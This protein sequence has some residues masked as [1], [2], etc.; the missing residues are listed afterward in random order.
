MNGIA[1]AKAMSE[2]VWSKDVISNNLV[3]FKKYKSLLNRLSESNP[4]VQAASV[5]D[6][7]EF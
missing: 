6:L 2:E 4:L 1:L 3:A 7:L 5:S